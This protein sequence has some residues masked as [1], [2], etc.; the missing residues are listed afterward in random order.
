MLQS[1]DSPNIISDF[2]MCQ[3]EGES[4]SFKLPDRVCGVHKN[5][6]ISSVISS[7]SITVV[8]TTVSPK[9]A[10]VSSSAWLEGRVREKQLAPFVFLLFHFF[11]GVDAGVGYTGETKD[12]YEFFIFESGTFQVVTPEACALSQK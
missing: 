2:Q 4:G 12:D 9:S 7:L 5:L 1:L 10:F 8:C 11:L 3:K 6:T